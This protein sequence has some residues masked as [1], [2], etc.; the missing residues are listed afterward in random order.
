MKTY[1]RE[2]WIPSKNGVGIP[3]KFLS[4]PECGGT[5]RPRPGHR[6]VCQEC[7]TETTLDMTPLD[8]KKR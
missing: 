4:C 6:Y 8:H 1:E 7:E 2:M 3:P 5:M